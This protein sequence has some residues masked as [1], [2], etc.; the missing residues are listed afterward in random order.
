MIFFNHSISNEFNAGATL[1]FSCKENLHQNIIKNCMLQS[2][3]VD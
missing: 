2:G 3:L 1:Q